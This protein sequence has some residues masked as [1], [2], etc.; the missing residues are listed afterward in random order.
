MLDKIVKD[1]NLPKDEGCISKCPTLSKKS[2]ALSVH[3]KDDLV[4]MNSEDK[5]QI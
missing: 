2:S 3:E 5:L 1:L 4:K